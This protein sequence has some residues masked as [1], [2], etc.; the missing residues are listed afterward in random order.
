M[1]FSWLILLGSNAKMRFSSSYFWIF[2]A[3]INQL[4]EQ[5]IRS[6]NPFLSFSSDHFLVLGLDLDLFESSW[7]VFLNSPSPISSLQSL[8]DWKRWS[9]SKIFNEIICCNR[10]ENCLHR[11]LVVC[12]W[13]ERKGRLI[14]KEAYNLKNCT[15]A[16]IIDAKRHFS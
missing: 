5:K 9:E 10:P 16:K 1:T 12:S 4:I 14:Q 7:F 8:K 15:L 6:I 11:I 2:P 13:K 3:K